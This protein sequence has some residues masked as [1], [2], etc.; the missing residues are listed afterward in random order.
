M[1]KK[2]GKKRDSKDQFYTNPGVSSYCLDVFR[3]TID[4]DHD[5]ILLEPSAGDGSFSDILIEQCY[6]VDAYDIEPKKEY[7]KKQNYL[8]F[9]YKK[10]KNR[11]VHCIGNPPF[12]LQSSLSKKF[13]KKSCE[14]CETISFI[15]PKSFRKESFQKAFPLNFHLVKEIDLPKNSFLVDEK[16]YDVPCVF[17]IWIKKEKERYIEPIVKEK[18]FHF[19][20]RPELKDTHFNG[21]GKPIKRENIFSEEPDFGILRAGGGKKCGRIS[22][23]YKDGIACYPEAWLFIKIN[24]KYDKEEFYKEYKKINWIDD[25]NVGARS[26][27]KQKFIRGINKVLEKL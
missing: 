23:E 2:T 18:G 7:I 12:G 24:G 10:Y 9:D 6:N 26:I 17:Q 15:L 22:K 3:D 1:K 14:F 16:E 5:D 21:E 4:I 11:N 13:I 19:V 27:D 25:S 20:K 8:D